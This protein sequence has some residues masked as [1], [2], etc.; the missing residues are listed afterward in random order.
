MKTV[1]FVF[2]IVVVTGKEEQ[3]KFC[4]DY[5]IRCVTC[6]STNGTLFC[7]EE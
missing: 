7:D 3:L 1:F 2:F 4:N 6:E 5:L